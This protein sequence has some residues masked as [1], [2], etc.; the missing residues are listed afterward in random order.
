MIK[1]RDGFIQ[2]I[3]ESSR[4][5]IFILRSVEGRMLGGEVGIVMAA[6]TRVGGV[7]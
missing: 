3:G 7:H 6:G 1:L 2:G 4:G 5:I